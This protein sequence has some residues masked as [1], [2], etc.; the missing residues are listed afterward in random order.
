MYL[1]RDLDLD[2][3]YW[4]TWEFCIVIFGHPGLNIGNLGL[5]W[6]TS[7]S[8]YT[9]LIRTGLEKYK[10]LMIKTSQM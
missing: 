4:S 8:I 6:N 7:K 2:L 1:E 9:S 3:I 5:G 10:E